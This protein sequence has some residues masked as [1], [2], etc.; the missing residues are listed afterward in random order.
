MLAWRLPV[1]TDAQVPAPVHVSWS[2]SRTI[3]TLTALA[4]PAPSS[5]QQAEQGLLVAA[6]CLDRRVH[7]LRVPV[8]SDVPQWKRPQVWACPLLSPMCCSCACC[9]ASTLGRV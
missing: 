2:I 3:F 7:W 6:T 5:A 9:L 8:T 4:P 1:K